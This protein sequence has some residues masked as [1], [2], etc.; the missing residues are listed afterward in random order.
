M[1]VSRAYVVRADRYLFYIAMNSVPISTASSPHQPRTPSSVSNRDEAPSMEELFDL[2]DADIILRSSNSRDF[3]VP[4]LFITKSSPVLDKLIQRASYPA[5]SAPPA[6][7]IPLPVIHMSERGA[8]LYNLLTFVLPMIPPVLPP[9][10]EETLELL[11]VAQKYEMSHVLA[12][13]RGSISLQ[14]PPLICRSNALHVY[15]LAQNYGLRQEVIQ[16]ARLTVRS[17]LTI[18]NLEDK[19]D[20]MPGD[21]LHELWKYHRRLQSKLVSNINDFRLSSADKVLIGLNCAVLARS[22]IPKWIDDYIYFMASAPSSFNLFEFQSALARHV[23]GR[24]RTH[25]KPCSFCLCLPEE[26]MDKFWTALTAFVNTN[27]EEV[28]NARVSMPYAEFKLSQAELAFSI[29]ERN[30]STK[31][32]IR[33]SAVP[34]PLPECLDVRNA[35]LVLQSSDSVDF[36]VHK[37]VL[38]SS[39]QFFRDMFSLPRPSNDETIDGLPFVRL[40]EDAELVRALITAMYPIPTEIPAPYDRVLILLAAAQKYDMPAVQSSIRAEVARRALPAPAGAQSFRAFAISFNNNLTP[41]MGAAARLTL[42]YPFTF[43]MLGDELRLFSGSALRELVGFRKTCR[44]NIVC[45]LETFLDVHKGPSTIWVGCPKCKPQGGQLSPFAV[46]PPNGK[47]KKTLPKWLRSVFTR[48]IDELKEYF[49]HAIFN[50]SSIREKYLAALMSHSPTPSDC[51]TCLMVHAHEGEKY[52]A[53]LEQQLTL[54][55]NQASDVLFNCR[56]FSVFEHERSIGTGFRLSEEL[57]QDPLPRT[58]DCEM[59]SLRNRRDNRVQLGLTKELYYVMLIR[60]AAE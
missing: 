29:S 40:S 59:L 52:C 36:R 58:A 37:V 43:E 44:D 54:A 39:S 57:I 20:V 53:G 19:L 34:P 15:S 5:V 8:I 9:S 17:T 45:C 12:H 1:G 2:P 42:D 6:S 55:R 24:D 16:A 21:H 26:A 60:T 11:W 7:T 56:D 46:S 23:S 22:K 14:D 50:P 13:I 10:V 33:F 25:G 27:M 48:Q 28:T 47:D 38:A 31:D 18:E 3:R 51:R 4:K 49:T 30:T 32:Y 41:E 35:D